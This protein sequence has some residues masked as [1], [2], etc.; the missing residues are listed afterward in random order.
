MWAMA[1]KLWSSVLVWTTSH[2]K[3]F[4][5]LRIAFGILSGEVE[6]SV[7][8][9]FDG[10][11]ESRMVW[12]KLTS[13]VFV[14][15]FSVLGTC[16]HAATHQTYWRLDEEF[17]VHAFIICIFFLSRGGHI[18]WYVFHRLGRISYLTECT[19]CILVVGLVWRAVRGLFCGVG[20]N[21]CLDLVELRCRGVYILISAW[22]HDTGE[23]LT[24]FT[25]DCSECS[26]CRVWSIQ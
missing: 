2:F 23:L 3:C 7:N 1:P 25:L 18:F 22:V 21:P 9:S 17:T 12:R 10:L 4:S 5:S 6:A 19:A 15:V 13:L 24:S 20:Q 16:D 14:L 8:D 11:C 26:R